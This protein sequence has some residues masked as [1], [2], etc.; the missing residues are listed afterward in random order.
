MLRRFFINSLLFVFILSG[1]GCW[2]KENSE[3]A[4][5]ESEPAGEG[6]VH[7][8]K[9]KQEVIGLETIEA[10]K[11]KLERPIFA[12]GK[13]VQDPQQMEFVFSPSAGELTSI[14]APMGSWVNRGAPLVQINGQTIHATKS[15]TVISINALPGQK[16][17]RMIPIATIGNT[18][19]IRVI[20][21]VFPQDMDR[22]RVGQAVEVNLIGH[23]EEIFPGRV[24][25]LSPNLDESSQSMKVGVDVENLGGHIKF[26]MFVHGRILQPISESAL[27]IPERAL[28]RMGEEYTVF[29]E[30]SPEEFE[31]RPVKPGI[32]TKDEVEIVGGLVGGERIVTKGAFQLKSEAQSHLLEEEH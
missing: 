4:H 19:P 31:K 29:V 22:V 13:A 26:G 9:K 18:N 14:L 6:V 27:V 17:D 11:K 30:I 28:V 20:F 23:E 2:K 3:E 8:S 7:L 5:P 21:D 1:A 15:G 10:R 25:Y 16:I 12:T 32:R 24:V